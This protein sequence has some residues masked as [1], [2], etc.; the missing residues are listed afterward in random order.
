MACQ[1]MGYDAYLP[2]LGLN[3][4]RETAG[5]KLMFEK[6]G[7]LADHPV[8]GGSEISKLTCYKRGKMK[9]SIHA[10]VKTA[11]GK[12]T[13]FSDIYFLR[14]DLEYRIAFQDQLSTEENFN[15][16]CKLLDKK[17]AIQLDE[18]TYTIIN[19]TEPAVIVDQTPKFD[20]VI[21]ASSYISRVECLN[22]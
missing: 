3:D 22:D 1:L 20:S 14:G 19:R 13:I 7:S 4:T 11:E 18:A 12:S 21:M 8:M 15:R 2:E 10:K 9:S 6:Q 5:A 16:V 17:D